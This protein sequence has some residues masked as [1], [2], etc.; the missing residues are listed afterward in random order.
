LL[1][2]GRATSIIVNKY[3]LKVLDGSVPNIFTDELILLVLEGH[4]G[5][6]QRR[7]KQAKAVVVARTQ[8]AARW[9]FASSR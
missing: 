1:L 5:K 8:Q 3:L 4:S 7:G 9:W 2:F 6:W